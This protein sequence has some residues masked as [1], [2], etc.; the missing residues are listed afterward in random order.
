MIIYITYLDGSV[1]KIDTKSA[2]SVRIA[3]SE[4]NFRY[5]ISEGSDGKRSIVVHADGVIAIIPIAAN[6]FEVVPIRDL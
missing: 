2:V 5:A 3:N 6:A 4:E 1:Q